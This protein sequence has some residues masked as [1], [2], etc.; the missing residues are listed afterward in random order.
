M[1]AENEGGTA[2]TTVGPDP[3]DDVDWKNNLAHGSDGESATEVL[4]T[5]SDRSR[6][7]ILGVYVGTALVI[8]GALGNSTLPLIVGYLLIPITMYRDA[9]YLESITPGWQRD[10]GL[11][12]LGSLLF[13][14]L[15]VP[16][17]LYRR[18]E[19]QR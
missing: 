15:V 2:D 10:A 7:W 4:E 12:L 6:W 1:P 11:L 14:F 8:L 16:Y 17:Y 13:P 3:G 5:D 19:L 18:R 9:G